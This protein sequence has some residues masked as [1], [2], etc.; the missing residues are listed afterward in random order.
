MYKAVVFDLDGTLLDSIKDLASAG[1]Y[2]LGQ[3]EL[4]QHTEAEF[5]Y[6]VGNGMKH[7]VE[8]MLSPT[9]RG[10]EMEKM[11]MQM[12]LNYYSLHNSDETAPFNNTIP[13]L[14]TLKKAGVKLAVLSNKD[15]VLV[16][17]LCDKHFENIFDATYGHVV[18]TQ[19]KPDPQG[20]LALCKELEVD[21]K[22][23]LYVGDSDI[24]VKTA[25]NANIDMC[26]VLWGY[27]T[28]EQLQDAGAKKFANTQKELCAIALKVE[29]DT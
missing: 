6:M 19:L 22:D 26:G 24:D 23:V 17:G 1:N 13:M 18:G 16:T 15:H 14:N 11:A 2:V 29:L 20:L 10:G 4:P 8:R 21:T 12:F 9:A 28:K 7:L 5:K 25:I 3:L 27:R